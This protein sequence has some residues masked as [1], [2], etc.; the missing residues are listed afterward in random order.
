MVTRGFKWEITKGFTRG[1]VRGFMKGFGVYEGI[2]DGNYFRIEFRSR[3][4]L[5]IFM[6][7]YIKGSIFV[8]TSLGISMRR[9]VH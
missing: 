1:I 5:I 8:L 3:K 4:T 7:W 6:L 2:Y 9:F